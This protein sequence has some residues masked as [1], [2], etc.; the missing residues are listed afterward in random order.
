MQSLPGT[1]GCAD[2]IMIGL[3]HHV[4]RVLNFSRCLTQEVNKKLTFVTEVLQLVMPDDYP[5]F[6]GYPS[7]MNTSV[8]NSSMSPDRLL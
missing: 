4:S 2:T 8:T 5:A 3:N 1:V 6:I 7:C